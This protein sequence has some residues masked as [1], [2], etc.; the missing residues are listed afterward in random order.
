L[1]TLHLS[2]AEL[3]FLTMPRR[4][5]QLILLLLAIMQGGCPL[6][7]DCSTSLEGCDSY[8]VDLLHWELMASDMGDAY[9]P[10]DSTGR[11][12]VANK[13]DEYSVSLS[14]RYDDDGADAGN[15]WEGSW[16]HSMPIEILVEVERASG[17]SDNI[18]MAEVRKHNLEEDLWIVVDGKVYDST[19]YLP[20]HPGGPK[21]VIEQAGE[22]STK[23]FIAAHS[24]A[25]REQLEDLFIG[26]LDLNS[27]AEYVFEVSR[28]LQT[29]SATTD[30]QFEAG[31]AIDF[32]FAFWVRSHRRYHSCIIAEE[33]FCMLNMFG[34]HTYH[35]DSSVF[36]VLFTGSIRIR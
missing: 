1:H 19:E 34:T 7:D 14:C 9:G 15:E 17:S 10:N 21:Y 33:I 12:E 2:S 18:T 20:S 3:I 4:M 26:Y 27:L 11:D 8:K 28:P 13:D 24:L 32:G 5:R 36:G 35:A 29:L 23:A 22:E 16:S 31:K 6:A 30:A 25:A